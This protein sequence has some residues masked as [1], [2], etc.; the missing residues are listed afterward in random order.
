MVLLMTVTEPLFRHYE[1]EIFKNISNVWCAA[2]DCVYVWDQNY[3]Y[4]IDGLVQERCNPSP[5]G[6]IQYKNVLSV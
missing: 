2:Q 6:L 1:D 3:L 5:L 4:D